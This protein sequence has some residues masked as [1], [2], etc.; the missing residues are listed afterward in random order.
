MTEECKPEKEHQAVI[1]RSIELNY[2]ELIEWEELIHYPNSF[3]FKTG[4]K[5]LFEYQS[6]QSFIRRD[7]E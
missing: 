4:N 3:I 1:E 7:E 2:D 6:N 5:T